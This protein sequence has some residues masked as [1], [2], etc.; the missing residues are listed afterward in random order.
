MN[1]NASPIFRVRIFAVENHDPTTETM[2]CQLRG[3]E[4][5]RLGLKS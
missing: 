5:Y 4:R 3:E 1:L 2:F